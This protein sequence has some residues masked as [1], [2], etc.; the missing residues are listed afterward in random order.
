MSTLDHTNKCCHL[1]ILRAV[2]GKYVLLNIRKFLHFKN[3]ILRSTVNPNLLMIA[4]TVGSKKDMKVEGSKS[5]F[6]IS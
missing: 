5:V 4:G 6:K 2:F 3:Q 1:F